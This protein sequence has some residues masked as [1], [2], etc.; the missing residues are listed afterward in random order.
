MRRVFGC[1]IKMDTDFLLR[2]LAA[3]FL[4]ASRFMVRTAALFSLSALA[5]L[6]TGCSAATRRP[7]PEL[8]APLP[9][10]DSEVV[11]DRLALPDESISIVVRHESTWAESAG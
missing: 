8:V 10:E 11:Y 1:P 4:S 7:A 5:L 9:A 3:V 2:F 6:L